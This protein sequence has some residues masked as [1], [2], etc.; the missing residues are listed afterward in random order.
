MKKYRI[1][2]EETLRKIVEVEAETPGLAV[3]KVE[4]KYN[5]EK[6]VLSSDDFIGTDIALSQEDET[7]KRGL[8][9]KEFIEYAERHFIE[10]SAYVSIEDK[11]RLAFG[12]LDNA[13][14]EFNE[15]KEDVAKN[16]PQVYLLYRSDVWHSRTSMELIALFSSFEKMMK[17]MRRKK[18]EFHL[19][20]RDLEEFE[21]LR[22]TQGRNDNF[23]YESEYLDELPEPEPERTQREQA[24]YDKVFVYGKSE[25][26]RGELESLPI[27]FDTYHV[28]DEE[29]EKIV[30]ETEL[31]TRAR[32]SL[33]PSE[34]IEF[35]NDH[36]SE[37]WWETMGEIVVKHKIPYQE[38]E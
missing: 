38:D 35:E 12:S 26:S 5:G 28:S 17:Y 19:T 15:H 4:D 36:H 22:Q 29:M 20:A 13:L 30:Q 33:G 7:V 24:F 11:I 9:D 2:I 32:L 10:N 21:N 14:Y 16:S 8:K 18:R 3:C 1:A 6:H 25:L 27:P 34:S 37:I 23:L 31:E